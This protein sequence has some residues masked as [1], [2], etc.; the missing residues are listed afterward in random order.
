MTERRILPEQHALEQGT[1]RL[2]YWFLAYLL[3]YPLP[4]FARPPTML[5][6]AA[7]VAGVLVFLVLYL[8]SFGSTDTRALWSAAGVAAIGFALSPFGGIWGVFIVYACGLFAYV[9]PRR[10][11]L[12]GLVALGA[13]YVLFAGFGG[14]SVWE[15]GPTLF[16]GAMVAVVSLSSAAFTAKS[17]ELAASREESR[18]L[19]VVAER[20]R[21]ARDLHDVLGHTLT[22]VAVKA[23]LAGRLIDRD[24]PAARREVEEIRHTARSALA[25]LRSALAGMR[26]TTLAAEI[27]GARA[28]LDS[29]G[30]AADVDVEAG[31]L[32]PQVE[33]TLAYVL[34]ES[35]TN[36]VRHSG[37]TRCSVRMASTSREACLEIRDD[38]RGVRGPEGSGIAGMRQRL[39][40]LDGRVEIDGNPGTRVLASVPLRGSAA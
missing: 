30:I 28:A 16:F 34:R 37:A 18:R 6:V 2:G 1:R 40:S 12:T 38:G 19:A 11:A 25:E 31:A 15:Y 8:R 20:E 7:S 14:L 23:D 3:L 29:A 21:I 33:T 17:I 13:V 36:V 5:A 24:L 9:E 32:P 35:V 39:A 22:V 26:S 27:T 10:R 4:W